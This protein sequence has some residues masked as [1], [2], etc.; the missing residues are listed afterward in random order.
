[1]TTLTLFYDGLCPLCSRE[2]DHY[3]RRTADDPSVQYIDITGPGFDATA[4][5]LDPQRIHRVMH[6][7]VGD[8]IRTGVD[9]FIAIWEHIRGFG[10]MARLTRLPGFYQLAWVG[11][12][13]FA[14]IRPLLP[15]RRAA[16]CDTGTCQ[17]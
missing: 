4:H 14:A 3:R 13:A 10:W 11:Y 8:D 6:V 1:M 12:Y 2:I 7:K 15:R 16:D 9:A 5:G 17:R